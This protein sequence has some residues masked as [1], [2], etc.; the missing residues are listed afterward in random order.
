MVESFPMK[1]FIIS[2]RTI[3]IEVYLHSELKNQKQ[4]KTKTGSTDAPF[5]QNRY[6]LK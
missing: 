1:I 4:N 3:Q 6:K 5:I 2:Q